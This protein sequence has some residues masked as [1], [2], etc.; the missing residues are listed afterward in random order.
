MDTL[1]IF[2]LSGLQKS[3]Q[4]AKCTELRGEYDE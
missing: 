1:L 2:F 3:E 4:W